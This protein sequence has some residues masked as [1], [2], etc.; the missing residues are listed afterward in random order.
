MYFLKRTPE[1][2]IE[3]A[4]TIKPVAKI[5]QMGKSFSNGGLSYFKAEEIST[6]VN[7]KKKGTPICKADCLVK[8]ATI[9]TFHS[10]VGWNMSFQPT[11]EQVLDQIPEEYIGKVVAF[12]VKQPNMTPEENLNPN[13]NLIRGTTTLYGLKEGARVPERVKTQPVIYKGNRIVSNEITTRNK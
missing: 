8:I 7:F 5:K 9:D 4:K 2:I 10:Q 6:Y 13:L 3:L 12:S 1:E 11:T